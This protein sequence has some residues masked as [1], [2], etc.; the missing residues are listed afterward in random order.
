MSESFQEYFESACEDRRKQ[1]LL[2][3]DMIERVMD[4]REKQLQLTAQGLERRLEM[5]NKL[6]G[7]VM[8]KSAYEEAHKYLTERIDGLDR[9]QS[10]MVGIALALIALSAFIGYIASHVF[11]KA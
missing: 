2:R 7:D 1:L 11:I 8:Q 9:V 6:R 10:R 5:L 4:E 3:I